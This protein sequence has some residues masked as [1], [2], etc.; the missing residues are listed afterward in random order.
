MTPVS[1][2]PIGLGR[3]RGG[4]VKHVQAD[5]YSGESWAAS[6]DGIEQVGCIHTSQGLEFDWMGVLIGD[7]LYYKDGAVR[8]DPAKRARTD[9]SLHEWKVEFKAA[10]DDPAAQ[11]TIMA[12]VDAIIKGTYRVLLSRGRRSCFVWCRDAALRDHLMQRVQA[13]RSEGH[14]N[15]PKGQSP[16]PA[17]TIEVLVNTDNCRWLYEPSRCRIRAK[18]RSGVPRRKM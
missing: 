3:K 16:C 17:R 7:D 1:S 18:S 10:K 6:K 13:A 9:R 14:S 11:K 15:S 5:G 12:K 4:A 2:T 8:S